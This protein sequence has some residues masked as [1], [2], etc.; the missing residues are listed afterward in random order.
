MLDLP[1]TSI[2]SLAGSV[3]RL[4]YQAKFE[5][6]WV[7][8]AAAQAEHKEFKRI[9]EAWRPLMDYRAGAQVEQKNDLNAFIQKFGR[10]F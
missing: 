7:A 10:G 6:G 2:E 5:D 8:F 9:T 3:T 1:V 4:T